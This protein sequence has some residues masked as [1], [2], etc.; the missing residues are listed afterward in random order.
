[1]TDPVTDDLF[2]AAVYVE[3]VGGGAFELETLYAVDLLGPDPLGTHND[4]RILIEGWR[5]GQLVG[6]DI[7]T[8]TDTE[9]QSFYADDLAGVEVEFLRLSVLSF[10][11][12]Y[13]CDDLGVAGFVLSIE[14]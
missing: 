2:G 3:R 8:P 12:V 6:T 11:G 9:I 7:F 1:M 4:S 14:E 13:K 10:C 5:D